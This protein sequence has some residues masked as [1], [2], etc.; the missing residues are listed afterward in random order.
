MACM[1]VPSEEPRHLPARP[2]EAFSPA[3]NSRLSK[4]AHKG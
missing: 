4:G 1:S 3:P 2:F